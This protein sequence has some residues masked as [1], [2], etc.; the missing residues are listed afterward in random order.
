M[1]SL[2]TTRLGNL[3]IFGSFLQGEVCM[4]SQKGA[5]LLRL[6]KKH[7]TR[8]HAALPWNFLD[9]KSSS[10]P[11]T[12]SFCQFCNPMAVTDDNYL[13]MTPAFHY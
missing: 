1:V 8:G 11:N 3:E 4:F 6:I 7:A 10:K 12:K 9:Q 5:L 2:D 13:E